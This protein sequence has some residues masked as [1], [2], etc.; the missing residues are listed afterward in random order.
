MKDAYARVGLVRLCRLLGMTRQ[1]YYQHFWQL[2]ASSIEAELVLKKVRDIRKSH[3]AMGGRKIYEKLHPFLLEHQIKMGRDALFDLL[4]ANQLLV[5]KRRRKFITTF[6][7]HWLRKWP[8]QIRGLEVIRVNQLWVS[9]ITYW[10]VGEKYTYISL[11]TDAYSRKIIGYHLAQTLESVET[12][13]ALLMAISALPANIEHP[14]WHHSDRGVQYCCENYVKLLQDKGIGISM[15]E[16]GDPLE[17]AIAERINGILK[18][19]YLSYAQPDD[20]KQAE[21]MLRSAVELYNN[22]RPHLS[23][24]LLTPQMVHSK[25]LLVEKLWKNYYIKNTKIVNPF[26]EN[27]NPVN[28]LKD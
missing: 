19:E 21:K 20:F 26:Q 28:Q 12:I 8:N 11:V 16:N 3:R 18:S 14:I 25:E 15:T 27:K 7:N 5:K 1:A 2:E 24:G 13:K 6:S 23:I 22:E 10:K 9:D 17:N 4:S